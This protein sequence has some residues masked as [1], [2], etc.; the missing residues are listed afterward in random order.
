M[1]RFHPACRD[2]LMSFLSRCVTACVVLTLLASPSRQ[3]RAADARAV[4]KQVGVHAGL[5]VL[6][7]DNLAERAL[8]LAKVSDLVIYVPA[9]THARAA[10]IRP[11]PQR[12]G[13]WARKS[14][15]TTVVPSGSAWP[16]PRRRC[17]RRGIDPD[18]EG[19][20][21]ASDST[22][23][24]PGPGRN[25]SGQAGPRRHRRVDPPLPRLRQQ[26]QSD[27]R[28]ARA[29]YLTKFLATPW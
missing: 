23:G 16:E 12:R 19:R 7:G 6:L 14:T 1:A 15:S 29:P 5:C 4:H 25:R 22:A 20:V 28:L 10:T 11:L 3:A 21:D 8:A 26:P 27:D 17:D 13:C 9:G 24:S 18:A 2:F